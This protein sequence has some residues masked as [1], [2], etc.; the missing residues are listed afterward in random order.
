MKHSLF[1]GLA[2]MGLAPVTANAQ[3]NAENN[4]I[5]NSV[6]MLK[7]DMPADNKEYEHAYDVTNKAFDGIDFAKR[8]SNYNDFN[9]GSHHIDWSKV[10]TATAA[11][12]DAIEK[13]SAK[14]KTLKTMLQ[15]MGVKVD[16]IAEREYAARLL[17][18]FNEKKFGNKLVAK[19][20]VPAGADYTNVATWD[21][22]LSVIVEYGRA[23]LSEEKRANATSTN[24][25]RDV[26]QRSET[27]LLNTTYVCVNNYRMM[28]AQ[29]KSATAIALAKV[30]LEYLPG[31]AQL[32][33]KVAVT[34]AEKAAEKTK[35]YFVRTNAYLFKLDWDDTKFQE[36][37][38]NYWGNSE[39]P[40]PANVAA[41]NSSAN[42]Q[43][44]YVG[45]SSKYA[46]AGLTMKSANLDKLIA[47]GALRAT[48]AAFAALQRDYDEF[49]PMS[50][51]HV[52]D[53]KLV[54]YIGTKEGV[55]AGDKFEVF[56][57]EM[58]A[59]KTYEWKKVG[60]IKVAKGSVWD[61]QEGA[62]ETLEGAAED[63][64]QVEGDSSLK[65]TVFSDKPSKKI[66]DGCLI[67]LAK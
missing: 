41:F 49:R 36:F 18:Y 30:T 31:L 66:G 21:D 19:W 51:L 7:L 64:E 9:L 45:R 34:A 57:R 12:M 15:S 20:H 32:A 38:D 35:G 43:L 54:A 24:D 59:D 25:L 4:Y 22:S 23:G 8:Y 50:S 5:R 52:Q 3:E 40:D 33:G 67:R 48:D 29:E 28:T 39:K 62:N 46:G 53:G 27:Q 42:Y 63:G 60:S 16:P 6:Y 26:C 65:Y 1:L 61:N 14:D 44:K 56:M 13:E 10:P 58:T 11:E 2:L 37:Y 55:K 17:K 47:R